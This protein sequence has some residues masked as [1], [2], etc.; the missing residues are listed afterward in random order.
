MNTPLIEIAEQAYWNCE[1]N[2]RQ[3]LENVVSAVQ[4]YYEDAL[5]SAHIQN[6]RL[7]VQLENMEAEYA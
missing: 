7:L 5:L 1:G 4:Q 3:A 6:E 2:T